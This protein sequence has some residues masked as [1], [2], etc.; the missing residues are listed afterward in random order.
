MR[1]GKKTL[2]THKGKTLHFKSVEALKAFERFNQ[3]HKHGWK[4]TR[5]K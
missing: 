1:T 5:R 2:K 4:P 3:A